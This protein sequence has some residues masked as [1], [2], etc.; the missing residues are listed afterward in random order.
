MCLCLQMMMNGKLR[1]STSPVYDLWCP[2]GASV[3]YIGGGSGNA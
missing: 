3:T 1:D 2:H